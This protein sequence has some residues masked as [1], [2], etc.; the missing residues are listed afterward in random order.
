MAHFAIT[1][2][3][4][5]VGGAASKFLIDNGHTVRAVVR[6]ESRV[7]LWRDLG[8]EAAVARL[9]DPS[10]LATAFDGVDGVFI[11]TPTWFEADDMFAETA[12]AVR[13]IG[14]ALRSSAPPK[15]VLLSS[16]G[17]QHPEG[18]G[19][20]GKLQY[21]EQAFADIPGVVSI[22][23]AWFMENFVPFIDHAAK[24]GALP[25]MLAP[26]DCPILMIATIDI[27]KLVADVLQTKAAASSFLELEGPRRYAPAEV[28]AAFAHVLKRSVKAEILPREH[29]AETYR[30]WGLTPRSIEAMTEMLIGFN[31]GHIAFEAPPTGTIRGTTTLESVLSSHIQKSPH[32][33]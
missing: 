11:M 29:W 2:I 7:K 18:T 12:R 3:S 25:S 21:M 27:G 10:A 14:Q 31:A 26:I 19:A 6:D 32:R 30:S 16:I 23:A 1:G 17:A 8:M 4:G 20:I 5:Q 15:T 33:R 22:R 28:A 24:N 13:A 9:D